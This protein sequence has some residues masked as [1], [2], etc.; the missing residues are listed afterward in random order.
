LSRLPFSTLFAPPRL[1]PAG[2]DPAK[3]KETRALKHT[4]PLI[5]CRFD[6]SGRYLVA[7]AQDNTL[8]R[9][10]LANGE[11]TPLVGHI[12]WVRGLAFAPQLR[13]LFSGGY[14]GRLLAWPLEEAQPYPVRSV[15]AHSGWIRALA[16]S[17]DGKLLASCGNDRRVCVWSATDGRLLFDLEGHG[18]HVYNVAFHPSGRQLASCDLMG[19]AKRWD[20]TTGKLLGEMDAA[21]LHRYDTG[22]RADIGGARSMTYSPDGS[23]LALAG[24]TEVTNAFA[25]V[26]KPAVLLFDTTTGKR[27]Q[28]LVPKAAFQG[29]MWGIVFHPQGNLLVGLA[30]GSGASL[31]FWTPD[32]AQAF[33]ALPLKVI[34]RDLDLHADG[35]R[36]ALAGFDGAARVYDMSV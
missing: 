27:K 14:D 1:L 17:R 31:F 35:K 34:A 11:C 20:L 28:L 13:L 29:T 6:P 12:S 23:L 21:V 9:W 26:G 5:G 8:E 22:F 7:S 10:N 19:V 33:Q 2:L 16:A 36:L 24:I 3:T 25:G 18:S 30:S 4:S 15:Q 32:Q